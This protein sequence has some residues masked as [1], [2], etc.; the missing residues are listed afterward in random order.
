M[1]A[2]VWRKQI[3]HAL[4]CWDG[5]MGEILWQFLK[6]TEY[7]TGSKPLY[8][9]SKYNNPGYDNIFLPFIFIW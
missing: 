4:C 1:L 9:K 6:K 8:N 7:I 3:L 2:R 5:K